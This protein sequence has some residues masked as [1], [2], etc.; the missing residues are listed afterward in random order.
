MEEQQLPFVAS[1]LEAVKARTEQLGRRWT[2]CAQ[3]AAV[4][5][6]SPVGDCDSAA[7]LESTDGA[8]QLIQTLITAALH[9][10]GEQRSLTPTGIALGLTAH[11][12]SVSLHLMLEGIDLLNKVLLHGAEEMACE[13]TTRGMGREGLEVAHRITEVT[14]E[15]RLA[16]VAGY[17]Q[18]ISDE[19][20][21]RYR[22]IRHDIRNPLGTIKSAVALLTDETVPTGMRESGRVQAMVVRNTRSLD[23]LIDEALGDTAA[24]L[25]AFDSPRELFTDAPR[26]QSPPSALE[27]RDD[28]ARPRERPDLEPGIF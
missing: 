23:Q 17:T 24:H 25:H 22:A 2:E 4:Y 12:K 19:L 16:A 18:A 21:E 5:M 27:K 9:R 11:R 1:V 28:L 13:H 6:D 10:A 14:S 8:G 26:E 3:L 7:S 20:R 15:L